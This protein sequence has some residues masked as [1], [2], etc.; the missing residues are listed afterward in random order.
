MLKDERFLHEDLGKGYV[1]PL[2]IREGPNIKILIDKFS[3]E[4]TSL[5]WNSTCRFKLCTTQKIS[6]KIPNFQST[7]VYIK[8]FTA[9]PLEKKYYFLVC[10]KESSQNNLYNGEFLG[11]PVSHNSECL[12]LFH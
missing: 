8:K 3:H 1:T 6:M 12:L 2:Q 10:Q 9:Q 7:L 5:A 11:Q 4:W